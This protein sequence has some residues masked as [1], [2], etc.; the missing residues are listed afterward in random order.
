MERNKSE[1]Q[2][3]MVLAEGQFYLEWSEACEVI[4]LP[5]T[6]LLRT[7]EK[8]DLLSPSDIYLYKN[9][10]LIKKDWV[11]GFWKQVSLKSQEGK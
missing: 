7:I 1:K 11:F 5:R 9:R 4:G 8:L 2:L 10:K 6:S 3:I